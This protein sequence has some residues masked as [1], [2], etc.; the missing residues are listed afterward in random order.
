MVCYLH[1]H[2]SRYLNLRIL[3]GCTRIIQMVEQKVPQN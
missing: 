1:P 3:E 2:P